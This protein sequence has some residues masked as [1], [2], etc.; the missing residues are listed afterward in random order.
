MQG[1]ILGSGDK[2]LKDIKIGPCLIKIYTIEKA[3]IE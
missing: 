1:F 2:V 3:D